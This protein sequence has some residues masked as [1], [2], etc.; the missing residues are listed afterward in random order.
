[1]LIGLLL[2]D[3]AR[4]QKAAIAARMEK[5]GVTYTQWYGLSQISRKNGMNQ[6]ELGELLDVTKGACTT[7]IDRLIESDLVVRR[8]DASDR[9]NQLIFL[10]RKGEHLIDL[11]IDFLSSIYDEIFASFTEAQMTALLEMLLRVG[12]SWSS[13]LS[14]D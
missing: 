8:Q 3:N 6:K 14:R 7:L 1:M 2:D 12:G 9:R 10:T 11:E 13:V 4:L 5:Y